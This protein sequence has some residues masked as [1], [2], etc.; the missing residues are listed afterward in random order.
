M[1]RC[2]GDQAGGRDLLCSLHSHPQVTLGRV[3]RAQEMGPGH[4]D[5]LQE[6]FGATTQSKSSPRGRRNLPRN[7]LSLGMHPFPGEGLLDQTT[8]RSG[9]DPNDGAPRAL[10]ALGFSC[11]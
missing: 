9:C 1:R 3:E 2:C 8:S 7:S 10:L 11:P 5:P 4:G 6:T